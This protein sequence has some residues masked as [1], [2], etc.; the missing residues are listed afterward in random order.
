MDV[1]LLD[2]QNLKTGD[3][4]YVVPTVNYIEPYNAKILSIANN[5]IKISDTP[6]SVAILSMQTYQNK[7][8]TVYA[9]HESLEAIKDRND[10]IY[11]LCK[12]MQYIC[13]DDM[14][15][16]KHT[17]KYVNVNVRC[18]DKP[19]LLNVDILPMNHKLRISKVQN[20]RINDTVLIFEHGKLLTGTILAMHND[21]LTA[22]IVDAGNVCHRNY[23][24][25]NS[26]IFSSERARKCFIDM[27]NMSMHMIKYIT[28]ASEYWPTYH[29]YAVYEQVKALVL[30]RYALDISIGITLTVYD[31]LI[32]TQN[33]EQQ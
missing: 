10:I 1:R 2:L 33:G 26:L 16:V 20:M 13:I 14:P 12:L 11:A 27:Q 31:K 3:T 32:C 5:T 21:L 7:W 9:S 18:Q 25:A 6:P 8:C 19:K 22:R 29:L 23:S 30:K 28:N 24:I 17:C 15:L 4:V